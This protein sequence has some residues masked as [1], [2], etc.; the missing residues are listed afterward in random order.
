MALPYALCQ[1]SVKTTAPHLLLLWAVFVPAILQASVSPPLPAMQPE[2]DEVLVTGEQPGPG[3]W[4]V[5]A[6]G[7]ELWILGTLDPLPAARSSRH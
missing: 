7:N 2:L 3:L 6:N 5:S 1:I 4:R